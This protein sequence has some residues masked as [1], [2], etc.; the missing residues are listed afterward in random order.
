[1]M[2]YTCIAHKAWIYFKELQN[3]VNVEQVN[4]AVGIN[5]FLLLSASYREIKQTF[6]PCGNPASYIEF[7][8]QA[9]ISLIAKTAVF[10]P[11]TTRGRIGEKSLTF[12]NLSKADLTQGM[13]ARVN[14]A[15][16]DLSNARLRDAC[17]VGAN[18]AEADFTGAD[19]TGA[20]LTNANLTNAKFTG[21]NLTGANLSGV[22]LDLVN[23]SNACLFQ[24]IIT[25]IDKETAVAN[26]AIFSLAKFEELKRLL[27]YQSRIYDKYTGDNTE[28]TFK[29][30]PSTGQIESAEGEPI[31]PLD[32][33]SEM[34][35]E[36]VLGINS[37]DFYIK[38]MEEG[39]GSS[40]G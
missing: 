17:L 26:G 14:F 19:L 33:D 16:T 5:V 25:E 34:E 8:P 30:T 15:N 27:S 23:L 6:S 35:D 40:R 28:I 11:E 13:L 37:M 4:A 24:A 29:E 10:H 32:L 9:L 31:F 20:N 3:P 7:N 36:T 38:G 39:R 2:C 18:L 22:N 1:L 12:L 21:A